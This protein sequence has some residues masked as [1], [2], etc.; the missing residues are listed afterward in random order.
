MSE[1]FRDHFENEIRLFMNGTLFENL[2]YYLCQV[3]DKKA[4]CLQD[5]DRWNVA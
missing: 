3:A 5:V 1:F 2:L 4:A